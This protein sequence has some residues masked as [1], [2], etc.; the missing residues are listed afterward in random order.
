[1]RLFPLLAAWLPLRCA[2]ADHVD[3][4]GLPLASRADNL[5][6]ATTSLRPLLSK[7]ARLVLPIDDEWDRLQIRGTSPRIHPNYNVVVEVAT[8]ADVQKTVQIAALLNIPFLADSGTH[9]WTKTLNSLPF[10]IQIN[11]HKLNSTTVD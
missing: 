11:M 10:G 6:A 1:M 3:S 7:N 9:G 8:E 4:F 5:K 2:L